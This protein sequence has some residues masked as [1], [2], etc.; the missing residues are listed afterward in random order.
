[1]LI[2]VCTSIAAYGVGESVWLAAAIGILE[3]GGLIA[4]T[5]AGLVAAPELHIRTM[6]P[7]DLAGWGHTVSGAFIAFLR[8]SASRHWR[9]WPRRRRIHDRT[10]PRGILG[11]VAVSVV[12]YVAVATASDISDRAADNPLLDIFA[13]AGAWVFAMCGLSRRRQRLLVQIVMLARLF[14]GMACNR[15]LPTLFA[16]VSSWTGTP[17]PAT[18]LAGCIVSVAALASSSNCWC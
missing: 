8:S 4:A 15:Q 13:G 14:Y 10:V 2:V 1:M 18:V 12:L 5:I 7:V 17:L 16:R 3:I 9:T 11:A 6:V